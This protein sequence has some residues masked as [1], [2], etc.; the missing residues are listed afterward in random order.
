MFYYDMLKLV[1]LGQKVYENIFFLNKN[2]CCGVWDEAV[3]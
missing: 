2:L 3:E 1:E